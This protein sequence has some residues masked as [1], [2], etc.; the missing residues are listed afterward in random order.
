MDDARI[1][2]IRGRLKSIIETW[3]APVVD[4]AMGDHYECPMCDGD[5]YVDGA[6]FDVET[7]PVY[8]QAYGIGDDVRKHSEFIAHAPADIRDMLADNAALRALAMRQHEMLLT[9]GGCNDTW[10]HE[11]FKHK[12]G[13]AEEGCE[14]YAL[15]TEGRKLLGGK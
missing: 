9:E 14:K 11:C 2:E 13:P 6:Q 15:L 7:L 3:P 8:V 10:C 4:S 1:A 12:D 5:G